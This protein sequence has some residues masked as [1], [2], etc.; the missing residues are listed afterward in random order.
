MQ[1][2]DL[3]RDHT[4]HVR[5][6]IVSASSSRSPETFLFL[7]HLNLPPCKGTTK[8][9]L[10]QQVQA[11]HSLSNPYDPV[12]SALSMQNLSGRGPRTGLDL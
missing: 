12:A 4:P 7:L 11:F 5:P 2:K 9:K 8:I 10:N 6:H 3:S 1:L